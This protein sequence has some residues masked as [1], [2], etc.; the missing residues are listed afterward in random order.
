M[1]LEFPVEFYLNIDDDKIQNI[2]KS[3]GTMTFGMKRGMSLSSEIATER[4][5]KKGDI[6]LIFNDSQE[7]F[8]IEETSKKEELSAQELVNLA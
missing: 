7:D 5:V 1:K 6:V 2:M 3:S 8:P 4:H